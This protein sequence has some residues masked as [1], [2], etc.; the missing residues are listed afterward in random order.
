MSKKR[1]TQAVI[2]IHG[3]GEQKPMDTLRG[4]VEAVLPDVEAGE[5][6]F[7]KP[8]RM[9]EEF[10]LRK[11]QNRAQPRTHFF[12][13]YW[14]DKVQGTTVAHVRSWLTSLLFRLPWRVPKQ[15]ILL[16]SITWLLILLI[17][18]LIASGVMKDF[19]PAICFFA[20][21][22]VV[23]GAVQFMVVHYVGDAAR[24]LSPNPKNIAMR[25]SIRADGVSLLRRIHE[26]GDYD[27]V[28]VVGHSLGSV[29]ADD[30][31]KHFWQQYYADYRDAHPNQQEAL[32]EAERVGEELREDKE[33]DDFQEKQ[34]RLWQELGGLGNPWLVT[35]LITMGSPLTHAAILLAKDEAELRGRQRQRELPTCPPIPEIEIRQ[36]K[37]RARYSYRLWDPFENDGEKFSLRVLHHAAHFASIRWTN[38]YFPARLSIFGDFIGGPLRRLFGLGIRDV[39]VKT[40]KWGGLAKVLPFAHTS[41]WWAGKDSKREKEE[42]GHSLRELIKALDLDGDKTFVRKLGSNLSS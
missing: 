34:V 21:S 12:E 33:P 3:V 13:Y 19:H 8:D 29:I 17:A 25:R 38:L 22:T 32:D 14:A 9:S 37:E 39:P 24:Y 6:Y 18:G 27:R 42:P 28:V 30:I 5:K 10:E 31:N 26:S 40:G 2:V 41:Y 36:G 1:R 4:F 23:M 20:V 16:W 7:S 11:L 35:D 15:L